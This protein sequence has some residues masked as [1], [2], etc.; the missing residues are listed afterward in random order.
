MTS[1]TNEITMKET[2]RLFFV[3]MLLFVMQAKGQNF[4]LKM[5]K[6][7]V[8]IKRVLTYDYGRTYLIGFDEK[9]NLNKTA[10]PRPIK[11]TMWYPAKKASSNYLPFEQYMYWD[12]QKHQASLGTILPKDKENALKK[13]RR[14][15]GS[16]AK[17]QQLRRLQTRAVLN[18][19]P[20]KNKFP[21]IVYSPSLAASSFDNAILCE[22]L[23]SQGFW[24]FSLP[25]RGQ[26]QHQMPM[27]SSGLEAQARDVEFCL[28]YLKSIPQVNPNQ[29][30]LAGFSWGGL[31]SLLVASRNHNIDAVFV[32]EN[33]PL[34]YGKGHPSLNAT[35]M[36]APV[37]RINGNAFNKV[38]ESKLVGAMRYADTYMIEIDQ[39][40]H[41]NFSSSNLTIRMVAKS[42]EVNN[43]YLPVGYKRLCQYAGLFMRHYLKDDQASEKE[44]KRVLESDLK[45][46]K[47]LTK[48]GFRA[49]V[50]PPMPQNL[51][52]DYIHSQG[53]TKA[54]VL[55]DK[56]K[57]QHPDYQL[58]EFR[59]MR[60][61]GW[62][63]ANQ[64]KDE[65]AIKVFKMM[66]DAYPKNA[67]GYARVGRVYEK[68]GK[69]KL[70]I[71]YYEKGI[72]V[73]PTSVYNEASRR[74]LEKLRE[75]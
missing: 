5:G 72:E 74:S 31:T 36:Y 17:L 26:Y 48:V 62:L 42:L 71:Q 30:G 52:I 40:N 13:Y 67:E 27:N 16:D 12:Y 34:S 51:F 68:L 65:E 28:N 23:A 47:T 11:I 9:G 61:V 33:S 4:G 32:L 53:I 66:I 73:D 19:E 14:Y 22:Y 60:D 20:E 10:N 37:M 75:K 64:K 56:Y 54:R 45:T 69:N 35:R 49:G 55:Y 43:H 18:A 57:I 70:A 2:I 6:Y 50:S 58:F 29:V 39:F 46:T 7:P 63:M 41:L 15:V 59:A 44:L 25:S 21:A 1:R 24:V 8:G 38:G 3:A